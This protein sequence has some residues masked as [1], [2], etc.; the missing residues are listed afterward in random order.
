MNQE[1]TKILLQYKVYTEYKVTEDI[2]TCQDLRS[3]HDISWHKCLQ[4][5]LEVEL[6]GTCGLSFLRVS[7]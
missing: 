5:V 4:M 3:R 7:T 6:Q 1:K 2:E